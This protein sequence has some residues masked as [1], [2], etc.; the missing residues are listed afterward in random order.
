M[1]SPI[2]TE[3]R[4]T[5]MTCSNCARKVNEAAQKVPGV[6]SVS[7]NVAAERASVRWNSGARKNI[8]AVLAAISQAGFSAQEISVE[9][10]TS[11]KQSRWR[12]NLIVGLAVTVGLMVGEWIFNLMMADWFRWLSF[13]LA[14]VV[15]VFC[16]AQFYRGAW[17]QLKVGQS[18]MDALEIGR[19]HV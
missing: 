19:A 14:I 1:S 16:G 10:S 11:R 2:T 4:V 8:S 12:W 15:Q 17:R 9:N 18:N 3:L 13:A 6:Y 7:V 5:G